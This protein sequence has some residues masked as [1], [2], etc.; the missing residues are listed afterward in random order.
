MDPI[1]VLLLVAIGLGILSFLFRL[2]R[3]AICWYFKSNEIIKEQK[4]IRKTLEEL[5]KKIL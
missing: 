1:V 5:K 2:I 3:E 4:E